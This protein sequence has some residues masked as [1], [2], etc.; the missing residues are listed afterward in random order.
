MAAYVREGYGAIYQPK[1]EC[2]W[3]EILL[4]S[5]YSIRQN[6][7]VLRLYRNPDLDDRIYDGF[8]TWMAPMQAE[9]VQA[10]FLFIG[11]L[12]ANHHAGVVEFC[13]RL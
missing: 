10:S 6:F 7:Y 3:C 13:Y 12:N 8:L 5:V 1:F 11:D 2:G 9:D 4:F